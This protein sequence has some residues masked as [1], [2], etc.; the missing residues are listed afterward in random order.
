MVGGH[1]LSRRVFLAAP[2]ST[3]LGQIEPTP[4]TRIWVRLRDDSGRPTAARIY[5]RASD[6]K[7]YVPTHTLARE[8]ARHKEVFFHAA[9]RFQI[10]VPAGECV[11]NAIKGFQYH[12]A[13]ETLRLEPG[14]VA[15]V[16][17]ILRRSIDMNSL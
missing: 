16:D 5:V 3:A 15:H 8:I 17:L 9:D 10:E 2:A 4:G 1:Y 13:S 12:T 6:T 11:I 7:F 14:Q